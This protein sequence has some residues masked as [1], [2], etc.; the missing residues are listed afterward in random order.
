VERVLQVETV[1]EN[2]RMAE[3]G[4]SMNRLAIRNFPRDA[5]PDD[6]IEL[7]RPYGTVVNVDFDSIYTIAEMANEDD[8]QAVI[9]HFQTGRLRSEFGGLMNVSMRGTT[10]TAFDLDDWEKLK[11]P[12]RKPWRLPE[13]KI[14]H[15]YGESAERDGKGSGFAWVRVGT[16]KNHFEW[17]D[18]LTKE[19]AEWRGLISALDY[20]GEGSRVRFFMDSP[21]VSKQITYPLPISN[22][23]LNALLSKAC[24]LEGEKW[25][26]GVEAMTISRSAN[27][28]A[29]LLDAKSA[30][31]K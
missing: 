16:G 30:R 10:E 11:S 27:L 13:P 14:F 26:S 21:T 2:C 6:I 3:G 29:K 25:L 19:E 12:R 5:N 22:P 23:R 15:V 18:G 4:T 20:V 8:A 24:D 9:A 28:A 17:M 1:L 7:F 31:R